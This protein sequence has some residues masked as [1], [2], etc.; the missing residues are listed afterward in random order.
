[1]MYMQT[2]TGRKFLIF[3]LPSYNLRLSCKAFKLKGEVQMPVTY[4]NF[5]AVTDSLVEVRS[6]MFRGNT[7]GQMD[8]YCT[9]SKTER[10]LAASLNVS[11][12]LARARLSRQAAGL[13]IVG[14]DSN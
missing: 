9:F 12:T 11:E 10:E 3:K 1:M 8:S 7:F 14:T 6:A 13:H 4:S 5:P 2:E